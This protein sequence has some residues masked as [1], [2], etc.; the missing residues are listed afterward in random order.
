MYHHWFIRRKY[1]I[2]VEQ[3]IGKFG[4]S[5]FIRTI[6]T[7]VCFLC[8]SDFDLDAQLCTFKKTSDEDHYQ[9]LYECKTCDMRPVCIVCKEVC[10]REHELEYYG[11]DDYYCR[12]GIRGNELCKA[13]TPRASTPDANI[14][15]KEPTASSPLLSNQGKYLKPVALWKYYVSLNKFTSKHFSKLHSDL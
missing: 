11:Y 3:K 9:H 8:I 1:S 6:K 7:Q 10:H 14:E 4:H 2:I 5:L 15:D 13:L 12:C